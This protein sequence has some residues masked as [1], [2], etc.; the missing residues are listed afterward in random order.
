MEG[1]SKTLNIQQKGIILLIKSAL[2]NEKYSLPEDFDFEEALKTANKHQISVMLFYGAVNCGLSQ[3]S[4]SM[5]KLFEAICGNIALSERQLYS[6]DIIF[7]AFDENKIDY[8]PLK[9]TLLKRMYPRP[10][11]RTMSDADILIRQ[12]DYEK[13]RGIMKNIGFREGEETNHE[14]KWHS[15]SLYVELHK[16]LIPSY[17]KDYYAYFGDGWRLAKICDG[18]RY[19]M[20]DEDQMIYLVTHFA[21]HYRNGG[22]GIKH[23]TDLWV[24]KSQKSTLDN[25]YIEVELQKLQ[26]LEFYK[27]IMNTMNVWFNDDEST[28][29]TDLITD[30]IFESG[31][32]GSKKSRMIAD[33]VKTAKT[34]NRSAKASRFKRIADM[35]FLPYS[36][37]CIKYP[38]VK[39]VP[40]LL[41][42]FWVV[43]WVNVLL[44][45]RSN[46]DKL[47]NSV[48]NMTAD[49]I[50]SFSEALDYVGLNFNFKE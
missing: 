7:K 23:M 6:I 9:G 31:A 37:M 49:S 50:D 3:E 8:L 29:K 41:P 12:E 45:K 30:F 48:K 21:K 40:I 5:Q 34:T 17:N 39:K 43:R 26:L 24:Y 18:T 13:I 15:P 20:T 16:R 36:G 46:L 19:S 35:I 1:R 42:V 33:G 10:E 38:V 27:N 28:D 4:A 14:L 32:Y 47:N 11:M 22:I 2:I 25:S 44:F